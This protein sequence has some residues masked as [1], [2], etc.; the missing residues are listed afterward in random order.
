M[1]DII[2]LGVPA[3]LLLFS[4]SLY[5]RN[6]KCKNYVNTIEDRNAYDNFNP[7]TGRYSQD[8]PYAIKIRA[9]IFFLCFSALIFILSI[10]FFVFL[11][12]SLNC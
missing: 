9:S 8:A 4:I 12:I 1:F 3:I 7:R 5:L 11:Q 10:A 6:R 2:L